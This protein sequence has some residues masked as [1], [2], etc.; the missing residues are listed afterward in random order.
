[1]LTKTKNLLVF[2]SIALIVLAIGLVAILDRTGTPSDSSDLRARAGLTNALAV[3]A[4]VQSVDEANG[5][6]VVTD[7]Y[8]ADTSRSGDAKNYGTWTVTLPVNFSPSSVSAGTN[9]IIGVD[10]KTFLATK[11]TLTALTVT[12]KK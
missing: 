9:V 5:T 8:L 11:H 3:N 12:I 2:G 4:T 6:M 1:M 10:S 7:L